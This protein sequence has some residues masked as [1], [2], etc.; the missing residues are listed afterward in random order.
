MNDA[1]RVEVGERAGE[2]AEGRPHFHLGI[3]APPDQPVKE[4]AAVHALHDKVHVVARLV[5]SDVVDDV[6]VVPEVL[7]HVPLAVDG[8]RLYL[9]P[10]HHLYSNLLVGLFVGRLVDVAEGAP[11]VCSSTRAV[12]RWCSGMQGGTTLKGASITTSWCEAP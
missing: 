10:V 12:R 1:L 5:R 11:A 8:R 2:V 3:G 4:L 7:E 6:G 9:R